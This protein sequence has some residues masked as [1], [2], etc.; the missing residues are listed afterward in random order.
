MR[1][2]N[3]WR[4]WVPDGFQLVYD[5]PVDL[6]RTALDLKPKRAI[7]RVAEENS[8]MRHL[9]AIAK[10][11]DARAVEQ[12]PQHELAVH[13][14]ERKRAAKCLELPVLRI[15]DDLLAAQ[16]EFHL[17]G[18]LEFEFQFDVQQF[19]T[20]CGQ[21]ILARSQ[22]ARLQIMCLGVELLDFR[23]GLAI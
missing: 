19:V 3:S 1:S 22:R 5:E 4:R 13:R 9:T 17:P 2:G 6:S 18:L 23:D 7:R 15:E 14:N 12:R 8:G 20:D 21:R 11:L 10:Q 16:R